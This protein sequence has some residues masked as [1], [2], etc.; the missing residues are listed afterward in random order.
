MSRRY[1]AFSEEPALAELMTDPIT[2]LL[3]QSDG[4]VQDDVWHAIADA[5]RRLQSRAARQ[6]VEAPRPRQERT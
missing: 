2:H 1:T 5:Q 6:A 4:L 3:M